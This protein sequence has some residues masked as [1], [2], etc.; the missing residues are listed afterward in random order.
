MGVRD[1]GKIVKKYAPNAVTRYPSL[2]AF[3]GRRFAIDANLLTTKFHF[4]TPEL[5]DPERELHRHARSWYYFLRALEREDIQPIVV[6]DGETRVPEKEKENARR[7]KARVEQEARGRAEGSRGDRLRQLKQVWDELDKEDRQIV[8]QALRESELSEE[9]ITSELIS[10]EPR[11]ETRPQPPP[12]EGAM[13]ESSPVAREEPSTSHELADT[14]GTQ[15]KP[16]P[17]TSYSPPSQPVD[18]PTSEIKSEESVRVEVKLPA[19]VS[20]DKSEHVP[21]VSSTQELELGD[22]PDL[23]VEEGKHVAAKDEETS[24]VAAITL[25]ERLQA[26]I[27]SIKMLYQSFRADETNPVYSKNQAVVTVEEKAFYR[28]ILAQDSSRDDAVIDD[29]EELAQVIAKSDKLGS[30]HRARAR[31]VPRQAFQDTIVSFVGVANRDPA[32]IRSTASDS[33]SRYSVHQ[34]H[35]R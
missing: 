25:L 12:T 26:P 7:W 34:A 16:S 28:F 4:G 19:A 21:I 8:A 22:F 13:Q 9:R 2:A 32:D 31:G 14:S 35:V 18:V 27:E 24:A 29:G 1:L 10:P 11:T 6:F 20:S 15:Q 5:Q 33:S 30:S 23:D 17:L 3:R